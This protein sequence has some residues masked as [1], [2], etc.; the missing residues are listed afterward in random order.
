MSVASFVNIFS[1]S[2]GCLFILFMVSFTVQKLLS[3]ISFHLFIFVYFHYSRRCIKKI[4]LWFMSNIEQRYHCTICTFGN[5]GKVVLLLKYWGSGTL[6]Q[7]WWERSPYL[8][9]VHVALLSLTK[10]VNIVRPRSSHPAPRSTGDNV[11]RWSLLCCGVTDSWRL[12]WFH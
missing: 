11:L 5:N 9:G 4:F 6:M 3:L 7:W 8:M 10:H 2:E 12:L 1:H